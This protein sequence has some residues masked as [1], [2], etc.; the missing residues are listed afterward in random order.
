MANPRCRIRGCWI[1]RW[2]GPNGRRIEKSTRTTDKATAQRMLNKWT[3]DA[4]LRRE[5]VIDP[6]ADDFG[7]HERR[8]LSA[9]LDDWIAGLTA[10]DVSEKQT[11][12]LRGRVQT[13][14]AA[15]KAER[16]S[17]L[18][19]SAV[20]TALAERREAEGLSLQTCQHYLRA[21]KQFSRWLRRDGRSRD[22]AL[23]HLSGFNAA[24]D[25]RYER[26]PLVADELVRLI[27]AAARGPAIRGMSGADR[28]M[29]YR[30]AAGTGFRAS[31]LRSLTPGSFDLDSD[32]PAVTVTAAYSKRRRDDRQPIRADLG[33]R[34]RPWLVGRPADAPVFNM[35]DRTAELVRADL[36]R[37]RAWWIKE[38]AQKAVRRERSA[39]D[40]L[41]VEDDAGRL[42]DFHALRATFITMLVKGGA[43]VKVAQE[44]ARHSDPKLTMNVYT[45]LGVHDLTRALDALPDLGDGTTP[46]NEAAALRATGTDDAS[47]QNTPASSPTHSTTKQRERAR[48]G[49]DDKTPREGRGD[50]RKS[51]SSA[52]KRERARHDA[53]ESGKA[54]C[55]TRT[56]NL[57]FTKPLLCQLS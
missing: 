52:D 51:M 26:R 17:G 14:L 55:E 27:D 44:L 20:Q 18:S 11:A 4:G 43:S 56:R 49:A 57:R 12:T 34:L 54:T 16:I 29:L 36:R 48:Q 31:E 39:S 37:A 28:A 30:V 32:A 7:K 35:P 3:A 24:T 47:A 50:D 1:G 25:R 38:T 45:R 21:I 33:E 46:A 2:Y 13:I 53:S 5:G 10:K 6:K 41:A 40:Y 42:V 15:V 8:P 22:D 9:H 23:A 19:A